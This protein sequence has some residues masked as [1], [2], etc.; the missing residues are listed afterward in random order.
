MARVH[1]LA[2]AAGI[3]PVDE[4][5]HAQSPGTRW[6]GGD[7]GGHLHMARAL[8]RLLG[9]DPLLAGRLRQRMSRLDPPWPHSLPERPGPAQTVVWLGTRGTFDTAV[10]PKPGARAVDNPPPGRALAAHSTSA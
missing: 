6:C 10:P 5:R 8:P 9:L 7:R 4:E 2:P 1:P 3:A